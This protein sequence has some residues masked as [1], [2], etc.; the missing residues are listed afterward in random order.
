MPI[1]THVLSDLAKRFGHVDPTDGKAVELFFTLLAT[2]TDLKLKRTIAIQLMKRQ[3]EPAPPSLDRALAR[4]IQ[5]FAL[6]QD[7]QPDH[8]AIV[9][10]RNGRNVY[11]LIA[12]VEDNALTIRKIRIPKGR[13]FTV[14]PGKISPRWY[15][16]TTQIQHKTIETVDM[17]SPRDM[18]LQLTQQALQ[19]RSKSRTV[20]KKQLVS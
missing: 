3:D 12:D 2:S 10:C 11:G 13:S 20:T 9:H 8:Y 17:V 7:L 4:T 6:L 1:P 15:G 16:S 5:N 14:R 18:Q 19:V